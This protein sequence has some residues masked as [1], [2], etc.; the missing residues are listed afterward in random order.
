MSKEA[1]ASICLDKLRTVNYMGYSTLALQFEDSIF[2]VSLTNAND[3]T[4]WSGPKEMV[5]LHI[6]QSSREIYYAEKC[7]AG[8][9]VCKLKSNGYEVS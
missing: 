7:D 1:K 3:W 6:V 5:K 2:T 4:I 9:R 8:D